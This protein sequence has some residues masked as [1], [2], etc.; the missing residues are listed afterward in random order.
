MSIF[1]A[2][3]ELG[4]F[5]SGVLYGL[6]AGVFSLLITQE[7]RLRRPKPLLFLGDMLAVLLFSACLFFLGVGMEGHLRYPVTCGAF[8]GFAAVRGLYEALKKA[9][10]RSHK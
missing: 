8:L 7:R 9:F 10:R 2:A 4:V 1:E 5:P 6:A 3:A